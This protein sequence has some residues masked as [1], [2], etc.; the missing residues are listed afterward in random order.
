MQWVT[1]YTDQGQKHR[2]GEYSLEPGTYQGGCAMTAIIPLNTKYRIELDTYAWQIS[3]WKNRK[4]RPDGGSWEG[5]SWHKTLQQAGD[6]LQQR[7]VA[8]DD[9]EGV[10]SIIDALRASSHLIASAIVSSGLPNSWMDRPD[11]DGEG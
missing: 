11:P 8:Q 5:L 9:L 10:Q 7:L 2:V 6:A 4:S 3:Q 1:Q